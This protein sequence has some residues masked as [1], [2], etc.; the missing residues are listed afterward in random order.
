MNKKREKNVKEELFL[1]IKLPKKVLL[2]QSSMH[3][4]QTQEN[5][6][7]PTKRD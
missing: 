3:Y 4:E 5:S 6:I 1:D 2:K 7:F